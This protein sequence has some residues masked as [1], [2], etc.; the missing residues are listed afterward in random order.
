MEPAIYCV[1]HCYNAPFPD[2]RLATLSLLELSQSGEKIVE[3]QQVP[4]PQETLMPI[5]QVINRSGTRLFSTAGIHGIA[6]FPLAPDQKGKITGPAKCFPVHPETFPTPYGVMPVDI[7]LDASEEHLFSCN[8]LAGT[9]SALSLEK[10]TGTLANPRSCKLQH[11]GIPEKVRRLG[12]SEAAIELGFPEGFPEDAPHPHGVACHPSG[13]WVVVCDLGTSRLSVFSLPLGESFQTGRPDFELQS[14]SAPGSNR[15]Q[16]AGPRQIRFSD[17]GQFLFCVNELDHTV[18]SYRFDDAT[19]ALVPAGSPQVNIPSAWLEQNPPRP[20]V[21]NAQANYNSGIAVSPDG[22]H[23]YCS[24]R[25]H[26]SVAGFLVE[27]DGS[28]RP[29]G[30]GWIPS[31]GRTPWSLTFYGDEFLLVANQNADDPQA[32]LPGGTEASPNRL[33]PPGREPGNLTV[34]KRDPEDGSLH[35]T[36]ALWEAP[37]VISVQVTPQSVLGS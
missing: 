24:A 5:S 35:P 16:Y 18:S 15:H 11:D 28:L 20:Y 29:T 8:F 9:V 37:H 36:G 1:A 19:G 31:G 27:K 30:Q 21:Y 13:R 6:S 2:S 12:P 26:D 17:D 23:V 7:A 32:R 25:G 34:L 33:A 22:R 14:H 3:V 4:F 10:E